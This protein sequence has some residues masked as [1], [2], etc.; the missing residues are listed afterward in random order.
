LRA[1][2]TPKL[3][4]K[5]DE[6]RILVESCAS[7]YPLWDWH[8]LV[9]EDIGLVRSSGLLFFVFSRRLFQVVDLGLVKS[10]TFNASYYSLGGSHLGQWRAIRRY[11]EPISSLIVSQPC[12]KS[13]RGSTGFA[14]LPDV[15]MVVQ[16]RPVRSDIEF[17]F[18]LPLGKCQSQEESNY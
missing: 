13:N 8:R 9:H 11:E 12:C 16:L 5:R 14:G 10:G 18:E 1:P 4:A 7:S 3:L 6:P 15:Y 2:K 17:H